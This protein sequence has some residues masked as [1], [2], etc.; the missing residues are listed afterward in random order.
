MLGLQ[1]YGSETTGARHNQVWAHGEDANIKS[2]TGNKSI[3]R[4]SSGSIDQSKQKKVETWFLKYDRI[5]KDAEMTIRERK[6]SY[7]L[8]GRGI[9]VLV[10]GFG[11]LS[12]QRLL[13]NLIRKYDTAIKELEKLPSIPETEEL[14]I[15]YKLYFEK[16]H[17]VF[18]DCGRLIRNPLLARAKGNRSLRKSIRNRRI[19]LQALEP[20]LKQIDNKLRDE[21][22]IPPH[23]K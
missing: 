21:F 6:E 3:A 16:A 13:K 23:E 15:K 18:V 5:R 7:K 12:A 17:S 11:R 4:D 1:F 8:R 14:Q 22:G 20:Q 19:E 10:P 2:F 9:G